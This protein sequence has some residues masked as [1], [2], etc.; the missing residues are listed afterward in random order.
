MDRL[1]KLVTRWKTSFSLKSKEESTKPV[2]HGCVARI[3]DQTA[4][5]P[6][7]GGCSRNN[8]LQLC[9]QCEQ[10]LEWMLRMDRDPGL[11]ILDHDHAAMSCQ[12]CQKFASVTMELKSVVFIW[13]TVD[14][15]DLASSDLWAP[16]ALIGLKIERY[17]GAGKVSQFRVESSYG[18]S[19]PLCHRCV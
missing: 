1:K 3:C 14:V 15:P 4:D 12:L 6:I 7:H 18:S 10:L 19:G 2:Q 17:S 11:F 5:E 16:G 8:T 13:K 9:G